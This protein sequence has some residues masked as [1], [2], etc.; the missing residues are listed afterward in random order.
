LHAE[1]DGR[2]RRCRLPVG[3]KAA[4]ADGGVLLRT[5][6][7]PLVP[8]AK[9]ELF[10]S[11]TRLKSRWPSRAPEPQIKVPTIRYFCNF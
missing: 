2:Q 5:G 6:V 8:S 4:M 11:G 3:D 9:S 1:D 7:I 10:P